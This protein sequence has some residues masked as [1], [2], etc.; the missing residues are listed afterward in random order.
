L[1]GAGDI[2]RKRVAPALRDL[3]NCELVSVS[4]SHADLAEQFAKAFGA[5]KWYAD[6]R[7]QIA[8]DEIDAV[9]IATPVY[10]HA[11]LA[12]AA[13]S[14]GKH[15]LCE[16]PMALTVAE[17]DE[18]IAAC[19][20]N[21]AK[22]GV[23]YY[24]RFFPVIARAKQIIADGEIGKVVV[25][26]INVFEN[27]DPP[28]ND[29]RHWLLEKQKSGGGPMIDFGCHRIEVLVNLFGPV[30]LVRSLVSGDILNREVEDTAIALL[31]FENGA[32][33]ALTVTHAATEPQDTLDIFGTRGSLHIPALNAGDMVVRFGD[34]ERT[35]SHSP[36]ANF[37][38]PLIADFANAVLTGRDPTVDGAAG[39]QV[40]ILIE[41]IYSDGSQV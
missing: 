14:A 35:E 3:P 12:I 24:R 1:I 11:Q 41:Q 16:K 23:A 10:M 36:D 6:W 37:H 2:A 7:Q 30:R 4:R 22:L 29:P 21:N 19:Q 18:M 40:S 20:K 38:A 34:H 33:A 5:R 9:Y 8:N 28:A 13:A 26:Q 25:A 39:R 15:V 17:C 32:A 31:Q 27:F